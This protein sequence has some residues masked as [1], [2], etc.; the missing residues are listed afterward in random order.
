VKSD[1]NRGTFVERL[2]REEVLE[3]YPIVWTRECLALNSS[4]R[5]TPPQFEPLRQIN[6]EMAA[7]TIDALHRQQ[8]D[9]HWHQILVEFSGNG[10]LM[11]L[12]GGLTAR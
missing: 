10:R 9:P 1:P 2:S 5:P 3:T 8:L 6:A 7:H 4:R 11:T 12:L